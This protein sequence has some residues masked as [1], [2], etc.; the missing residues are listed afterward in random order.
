MSLQYSFNIFA[1]CRCIISYGDVHGY[2]CMLTVD[3]MTLQAN[4]VN[5]GAHCELSP[6]IPMYTLTQL[7]SGIF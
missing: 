6:C 1:Q 7:R 4:I 5:I 2:I 3:N